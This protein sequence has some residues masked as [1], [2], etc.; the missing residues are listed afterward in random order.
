MCSQCKKSARGNL[1]EINCVYEGGASARAGGKKT[2]PVSV[3]A[4]AVV[5]P[6]PPTFGV[7]VKPPPAPQPAAPDRKRERDPATDDEDDYRGAAGAPDDARDAHAG[8]R[9]RPS[10]GAGQRVETLVERISESRRL[11][12]LDLH[13]TDLVPPGELERRLR[14]QSQPVPAA[15]HT[16]VRASASPPFYPAPYLPSQAS[17]PMEARR[18]M[19][20]SAE[21]GSEPTVK[22][23]TS[24][25]TPESSIRFTGRP[26]GA[27]PPEMSTE[28]TAESYP[29]PSRSN[30]AS[31]IPPLPH[32][33]TL[34]D[35]HPND[36]RFFPNSRQ[37]SNSSSSFA[38]GS[39]YPPLNYS[40]GLGLNGTAPAKQAPNGFSAAV[41]NGLQGPTSYGIEPQPQARSPTDYY[42]NQTQYQGG[43]SDFFDYGLQT[44]STDHS[45]APSPEDS[46]SLDASL[47]QML[48]PSWP[49]SLPLPTTVHHLLTVFFNRK[50]RRCF[51]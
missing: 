4:G 14:L 49:K 17:A 33:A 12:A 16:H 3:S 34:D 30:Y 22:E 23:I 38:N 15:V 48:Y 27:E 8:A 24:A 1:S 21:A 9:K 25:W 39:S 41:M 43:Q 44:P 51:S 32:L 13:L 45:V 2:K 18:S 26:L 35:G 31:F 28:S 11:L 50:F 29:A 10:A 37:S 6:N 47:L 5:Q 20:F 19:S 42:A 40:A 36:L 46:L 7:S